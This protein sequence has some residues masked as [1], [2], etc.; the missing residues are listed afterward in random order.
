MMRDPITKAQDAL[1]DAA[2]HVTSVCQD[3]T[4]IEKL[5]DALERAACALQEVRGMERRLAAQQALL[6]RRVLRIETH[7]LYRVW[8]SLAGNAVHAY[9]RV[10]RSLPAANTSCADQQAYTVWTAHEQAGAPTP[11]AVLSAV[12]GWGWRPRISVLLRDEADPAFASSVRS[13]LYPDWEI[14][15]A[16]ESA[17]GDYIALFVGPGI[18]APYALYYCADALRQSAT[19][20][21]H[22]DGG[23]RRVCPVFKPGWSPVLLG[24][25]LY[26]GGF[27]VAR[28]ERLLQAGS[29][30][31]G[32]G[33]AWLHQLI[34]RMA[35]NPLRVR[36]VPRVLFHRRT[37]PIAC[38]SSIHA[39]E[40][41]PAAPLG[42][43]AVVCSRSPALLAKCLESIR[44]T[45][46]AAVRQIVVIAHEEGGPNERLRE[47]ARNHSADI[48]PFSGVFNFA[49]MNNAGAALARSE[50]LLFL[51]DD[52][53]ATRPGW[54]ER[55][56]LQLAHASTGVVGAVL[57]YPDG[58]VQ[59]AGIAAGLIDGVGHVGRHAAGESA[60]WPWLLRTR[61]VSAVTGACLAIRTELFRE[62]GGFDPVFPNN[63]N[64][65][66]LCFRCRE[67]GGS[68]VCVAVD[69]LVH[70][71]CQT[72]RGIVSFEERYRFYERWRDVLVR[73]DPWYSTSLAPVEE[74]KLNLTNDEG[75]RAVL[76]QG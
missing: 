47:V 42:M 53:E 24:S 46:A 62:L 52:I 60:L 74:I 37:K 11:E 69:G 68:V 75:I 73:P 66:D 22:L 59:H 3:R 4:C 32:P 26:I 2:A 6:D 21:D 28:R 67:R 72:R 1:R 8:K 50:A 63:Y 56:G 48:V 51:N 31:S 58:S 54:A 19:D 5:T 44:R 34:L 39:P 40:R 43:T 49:V 12:A 61:E 17:T 14:C 45:A 27:I 64:D 41:E 36:H 71:E 38:G 57:R 70:R 18:L 20:E 9:R 65:V 13:Q 16:A 23:G 25:C 30:Y 7:P 29:V 15:T 10:R 55:L 76:S 33:E 35:Q